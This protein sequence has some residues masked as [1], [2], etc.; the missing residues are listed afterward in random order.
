M[1]RSAPTSP[2][3]FVEFLKADRK[4]AE[5]LVKIANTPAIEYRPQ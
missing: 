1:P 5:D 4:A 2:S 3:E